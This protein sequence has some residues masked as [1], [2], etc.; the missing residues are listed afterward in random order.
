MNEPL[1]V[2]RRGSLGQSTALIVAHRLDQA[3]AADRVV[4]MEDGRIVEEGPHPELVSAG[5]RYARLWGAWSE[6]RRR[7][8]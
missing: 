4:V 5:G 6:G 2:Y 1:H 3:A 7:Q 8:E